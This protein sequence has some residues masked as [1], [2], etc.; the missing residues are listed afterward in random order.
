MSTG[1]FSLKVLSFRDVGQIIN[2]LLKVM[3]Y[4]ITNN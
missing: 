2:M 1:G 3:K 4:V